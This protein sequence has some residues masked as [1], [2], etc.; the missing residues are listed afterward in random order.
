MMAAPSWRARIEAWAAAISVARSDT[1]RQ[2][3]QCR[4]ASEFVMLLT[5]IINF[6]LRT[7][8][9][10]TGGG[11]AIPTGSPA[12]R[13]RAPRSERLRRRAAHSGPG[14]QSP[15]RNL[16]RSLMGGWRPRSA[17]PP[18]AG[19]GRALRPAAAAV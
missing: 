7:R 4:D 18:R 14:T 3:Q 10:A 2:A 19:S 5:E 6:R 9:Q 12:H 13:P 1:V 8:E 17:V 15:G 16:P 11:A